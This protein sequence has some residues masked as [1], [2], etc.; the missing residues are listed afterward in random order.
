M[1]DP[2]DGGELVGWIALGELPPGMQD[3]ACPFDRVPEDSGVDLA[4]RQQLELERGD[5][6]EAAAASAQRPEPVG[7]VLAINAQ[8]PAVGGDHL[9]RVDVVGGEPVLAAHEADT[10]AERVADDADVW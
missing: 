1:E 8:Q 5:D 7:L 2:A 10:A 9:D 6:A 4:D 3:L